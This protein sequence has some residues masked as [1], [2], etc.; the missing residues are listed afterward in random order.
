M[1]QRLRTNLD[2]PFSGPYR[3][4]AIPQRNLCFCLASAST[5]LR[6]KLLSMRS[7]FS[8]LLLLTL[9][10]CQLDIW[11]ADRGV[12]TAAKAQPGYF[13]THSNYHAHLSSICRVML[14]AAVPM[15]VLLD[16]PPKAFHK[17]TRMRRAKL[18][19]TKHK[20]QQPKYGRHIW[21]PLP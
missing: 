8:D 4:A 13:I 16:F 21:L 14:P 2:Q 17:S 10:A 19:A 3:Q 5:M 9:P 6:S 20:W 15:L 11:G 1:R 18:H 12:R 7:A